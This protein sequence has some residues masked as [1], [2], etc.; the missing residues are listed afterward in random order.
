MKPTP[1]YKVIRQSFP[2]TLTFEMKQILYIQ[3]VNK[4]KT[5]KDGGKNPKMECRTRT[6]EPNYIPHE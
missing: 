1:I 4:R 5:N 6:S 3:K 2:V